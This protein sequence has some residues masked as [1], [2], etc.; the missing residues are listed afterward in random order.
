MLMDMTIINTSTIPYEIRRNPLKLLLF[1]HSEIKNHKLLISPIH[2]LYRDYDKF[3][4]KTEQITKTNDKTPYVYVY[5]TMSLDNYGHFVIDNLIPLYKMIVLTQGYNFNRED[6]LFCFLKAPKE[7]EHQQTL[8]EKQKKLLSVFSSHPIRFIEEIPDMK[9]N[10]LIVPF[11]GLGESVAFMKW[12]Q[13]DKYD[14][15]ITVEFL[16]QF[17]KRIYKFFEIKTKQPEKNIFLSRA[18]AKHRKVLNESELVKQ[19][20]LEPVSFQNKTISEELQLFAD[21][22]QVITPYGAG[23]VGCYF[24]QP[25]TKCIIIHPKGFDERY[26]F[27]QIYIKF[28]ERLGIHVEIFNNPIGRDTGNIFRNRDSDITVD[29]A[30]LKKSLD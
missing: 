20:K 14:E 28:M 18:G 1:K 25:G 11:L 9:I 21:S 5:R 23:I 30:T 12:N 7:T 27:P 13:Y 22:K 17:Q 4:V 19:L 29:I 8:T 10:N 6:V 16:K 2:R 26:D 3:V 24:M 15:S